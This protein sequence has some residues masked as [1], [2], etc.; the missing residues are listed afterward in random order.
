[1][2]KKIKESL[3]KEIRVGIF[4]IF[5]LAVIIG[6]V[7]SIG[8]NSKLFEDK[9]GY[10]IFFHSTGGL[11]EGDPVL[12]NGLE[13]GNVVYLGFPEKTDN[14]NILV[15]ISISKEVAPRIREDSRARIESASLVYG[16]V[17]E[18]TMGSPTL[19]AIEPG[20]FIETRSS[21]NYTTIV[22]STN[23]MVGDIRSTISK[24]NRGQGALGQ[25]V[26]EPMGIQQTM[27]NLMETSNY[28]ARILEKVECEETPVGSLLSDSINFKNTI[29]EFKASVSDFRKMT[30]NLN[31]EH[32]VAGKIIN[33]K[34]YGTEIMKDLKSAAHSIASITAK[35]DSGEGTLGGLVNDPQVYLGLRDVILGVEK[36]SLLKWIINNRKKAGEQERKAIEEQ[37][38]EG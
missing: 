34:E 13:V 28:L 10:K 25:L 36:S 9:V 23:L 2:K 1:M 16:K 32:T 15:K 35:I 18:L 27:K 8:G 12:L 7:F 29:E 31:D 21:T 26:N 22:D 11:F 14:S 3:T 38:K 33:D 24:I 20:G 37:K 5:S 19:P 4:I 30:R 6:F 17:V